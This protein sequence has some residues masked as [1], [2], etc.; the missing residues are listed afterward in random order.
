MEKILVIQFVFEP[1]IF[2]IKI[3]KL[4]FKNFS[5]YFLGLCFSGLVSFLTIPAII[6]FYGIEDYGKFSLLQNIVLIFISF[7]GGWLNQCVLRF[8]DHSQNFKFKIF[9]LYFFLIIPLIILYVIVMMTFKIDLFLCLFGILTIILGVISL[10]SITFFQSSL[11]ARKSFYFDLIRVLSFVFSIYIL[12]IVLP[13]SDSLY[14]LIFSLFFSYFISFTYILFIDF[15]FIRSVIMLFFKK[16]SLK[17]NLKL[18]TE[19]KYLF[20]YG[21]PIAFWFT[22]ASVL[23]VSDRY[24]ISHYSTTN[25]LGIYSA[26]YDLLY[27]GVTLLYSPILVA[28]YPIM[29]QKFN[30]GFK[31]DAFKFLRKLIFFEFIIFFIVIL[32]TC[33]FKVFFI[34]KIVGIAVTHKSLDIIVPIICGA[35]VWQLSMLIHK[36]LEFG[37]KS[38]TMLLIVI[39]SLLFNVVLNLIFIPSYGILFAA[40]STLFSALI[41][42]LLSLVFIQV[43]KK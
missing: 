7:G 29:T 31:Q 4:F 30:Q 37:L 23:N 1:T 27:K 16:N 36:P 39:I 41:Y 21:W 24:I 13:N 19:S 22:V 3:D 17:N 43:Y 14:L 11:N 42:L 34:E 15:H 28:G 25:D 9:Q 20:N 26:I 35:F 38:K 33:F 40:Y 32:I 10:I 6:K 2:M 12:Y 5:I 18:V 8:N